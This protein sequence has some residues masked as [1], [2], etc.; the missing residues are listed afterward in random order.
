[1]AATRPARIDRSLA[2]PF[3]PHGCA[4][5]VIDRR[6]GS[7]QCLSYAARE[8]ECAGKNSEPAD[9]HQWR[10]ACLSL[11]RPVGKRLAPQSKRPLLEGT[12]IRVYPQNGKDCPI[13]RRSS[14]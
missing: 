14:V 7:G 2:P 4:A 11:L 10:P 6:R 9:P 3:E 1:M 5:A 8:R 13:C 12:E